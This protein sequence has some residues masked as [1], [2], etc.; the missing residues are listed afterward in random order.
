M[1]HIIDGRPERT[2][3][4]HTKRCE[5]SWLT[6]EEL[7]KYLGN[8]SGKAVREALVDIGYKCQTAKRPKPEAVK[9][10]LVREY[11]HNGKKFYKWKRKEMLPLLKEYFAESREEALLVA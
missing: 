3:R 6:V 4:G 8:K 2:V 9:K 10:G 1:T 5:A 11:R 7:G